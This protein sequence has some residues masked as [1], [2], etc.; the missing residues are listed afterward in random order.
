MKKTGILIFVALAAIVVTG[1]SRPLLTI[2]GSSLQMSPEEVKVNM[3][4]F[5]NE[6]LLQ[7]GMKAEIKKVVSENGIYKIAISLNDGQQEVE[8]YATKDGKLFFPE[9]INIDEIKKKIQEMKNQQQAAAQKANMEIPKND[10]PTVD[11][12]TMS[13]CPFGNKAEDTL[14]PVYD[15]LKNKVN[16]NFH[17]IV[18][19]EGDAIRSLH[20]D[21]EVAQN[22]REACVLKTYG[23]DKWFTFVSYI[24]KNCSSDGSCWEAGIKNAGLSVAAVNSCVSSQGVTLMKENEKVSNAAGANGSPTFLINEVLSNVVYSYGDSE[25]YKKAICSAF[26]KAPAECAKVLSSATTTT[27]G[28]SCQ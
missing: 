22:E 2:K 12:Y 26:N 5:I 7:A 24:N 27:Q 17:Y 18:N 4:S 15:L 14:K 13:F 9:A 19:S 3:E 6:N 11:L 10:K 28:G 16:F 21:K 23:K 8:S 1:C 25:G 20:G